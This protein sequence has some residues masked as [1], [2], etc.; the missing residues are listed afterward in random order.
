MWQ[1]QEVIMSADNGDDQHL[2]IAEAAVRL[3]VS[4]FT[5]RRRVRS[6]K[7]AA[8][9]VERPQGFE[10]KVI[11][12]SLPAPDAADQHV[13]GDHVP[14]KQRRAVGDQVAEGLLEMLS[15]ER[16][17]VQKL[18]QERFELAGR[19]GF[20]QAKNAELEERVKLL[21]AGEASA[22]RDPTPEPPQRPWWR[23]WRSG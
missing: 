5:V 23:F 6:G 7:L 4:E 10:W 9:R 18:E 17:R 1:A 11:A 13:A 15:L 22:P 14:P 19:L 8:V 3:G 2:S 16:E 21:T 12:G 20:L